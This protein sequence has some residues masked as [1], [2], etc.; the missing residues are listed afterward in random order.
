[1]APFTQVLMFFLIL[2]Y[3]PLKAQHPIE[4]QQP[5]KETLSPW[6]LSLGAY[7]QGGITSNLRD[8]SSIVQTY[9]P[10]LCGGGPCIPYNYERNMQGIG[11]SIGAGVRIKDFLEFHY[12]PVLRYDEIHFAEDNLKRRHKEF[13]INHRIGINMLMRGHRHNQYVGISYMIMNTGKQFDFYDSFQ[14]Q[15]ATLHL[16]LP[17]VTFSYGRSIYRNIF[18]EFQVYSLYR[19]LPHNHTRRYFMY[20]LAIYYNLDFRMGNILQKSRSSRN[21]L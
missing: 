13:I 14:K 8:V 1:M 16:Q 9:A 5:V 2:V 4:V 10:P 15:V 17:A 21:K 11:I 3:A 18:S 6:R 20:G 19:G 7:W 12:T